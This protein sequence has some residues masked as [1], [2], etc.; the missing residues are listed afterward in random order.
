MTHN[1]RTETFEG[2]LLELLDECWRAMPTLDVHFEGHSWV[3]AQTSVRGNVLPVRKFATHSQRGAIYQADTISY[4]PVDNEPLAALYRLWN[5]GTVSA[6]PIGEMLK[7]R[8]ISASWKCDVPS[9]GGMRFTGVSAPFRDRGLKLAH[10][11]D[12]AAGLGGR[13]DL[14]AI[15]ARFTRSLSPLNVFLFPSIRAATFSLIEAPDGWQPTRVDWAEDAWVRGV[16]LGRMSAWIG[17]KG[18]RLLEAFQE[19]FPSDVRPNR[20]WELLAGATRIRVEPRASRAGRSARPSAAPASTACPQ[21]D[22][23]NA[24]AIEEAI[25]ALRRWRSVHPTVT[26]LDGGHGSNP[27]GW[28]HIRVDGYQSPADDFTSRYGSTFLG[29]D[30]NGVVNFHGDCKADAIDRFVKLIEEAE[31]YRDVL[32]PSATYETSTK[33]ASRVVKPKFALQGYEDAV[34]GFFLYHDQW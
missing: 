4:M 10:L 22:S 21:F 27:N 29:N 6:G 34:G 20:D 31:D 11:H 26:Q 25:D 7:C 8:A 13:H 24:I 15:E 9:K 1:F 2:T 17:S 14:E 23:S 33:P 12:A 5:L 3:R 28:I 19:S 16:A 32:R 30:Y 18:E